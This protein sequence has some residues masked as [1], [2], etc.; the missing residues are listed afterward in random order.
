MKNLNAEQKKW[1]MTGSLLVVLGFNLSIHNSSQ[2]GQA[3]L[4]SNIAREVAAAIPT[5]EA[6]EELAQLN[7][8][9]AKMTKFIVPKMLPVKDVKVLE[10]AVKAA[11]SAKKEEPVKTE[12]AKAESTKQT[13]A[14]ITYDEN[15]NCDVI[16]TNAEFIARF[17]KIIAEKNSKAEAKKEVVVKKEKEI[18]A[19]EDTASES[20]DKTVEVVKEKTADE[21]TLDKKQKVQIAREKRAFDGILSHC[22]DYSEKG[23]E[24][25]CR[26][27]QMIAL[28]KDNSDSSILS[29]DK[30]IS[31]SAFKDFYTKNIEKDMVKLMITEDNQVDTG[32]GLSAGL[33]VTQRLIA[34]LPKNSEWI[35]SRA[36]SIE[37]AIVKRSGSAYQSQKIQENNYLNQTEQLYKQNGQTYDKTKDQN[38]T[39]MMQQ[40]IQSMQMTYFLSA[41]MDQNTRIGLTEAINQGNLN[42][43]R[44]MNYLNGFRANLTQVGNGMVNPL[45]SRYTIQ[46]MN[47]GDSTMMNTTGQLIGNDF[48]IP[49]TMMINV[50][51]NVNPMINGLPG[52]FQ[53]QSNLSAVTANASTL[54]NNAQ[55]VQSNLFPQ[56]QTQNQNQNQNPQTTTRNTRQAN[57]NFLFPQGQ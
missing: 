18:V 15:C 39:A 23:E 2:V 33:K 12:A 37:A 56:Q 19:K 57:V 43:A 40:S 22:A 49:G 50:N 32:D 16:N 24:M 46:N 1:I 44:A 9:P 31:E 47:F 20:E 6:A 17:S 21:T 14:T 51:Q 5:K 53:N 3:D 28:M 11:E 48:Q 41:Q 55:P 52:S 45:D 42:Q 30:K 54:T 27:E 36:L 34:E 29:K 13:I 8:A 4:S 26:A 38:Y 7:N 25:D 35:R 10:K